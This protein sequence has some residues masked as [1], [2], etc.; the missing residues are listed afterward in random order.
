MAKKKEKKIKDL[1]DNELIDELK[2]GHDFVFSEIIERYQRKLFSYL[3]RLVHH[4][5]EAEDLLQNVFIKVYKHSHDFDSQRKF[6]SWVYRIAH[7]EAVNFLKR[8]AKKIFIY[9]EDIVL[10]KDKMEAERGGESA[11]DPWL[12]KEIK[13][14]VRESIE[15][16]PPK[17]KDILVMRY[18]QE[19][20][21]REISKILKK[22]VNTV[23]TLINRAKRNLLEH[24]TPIKKI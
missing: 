21:Y 17:Y 2:R 10:T 7:N 8:R 23:G 19:K 9:W 24:I 13:K 6:S 14:E 15:K 3:Y 12:V 18:F 1:S 16:L 5:D 4:R 22:P 11:S 20:S